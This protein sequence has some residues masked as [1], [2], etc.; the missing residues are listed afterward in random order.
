MKHDSVLARSFA[1]HQQK[2][3]RY[4]AFACCLLLPLYFCTVLRPSLNLLVCMENVLLLLLQPLAYFNLRFLPSSVQKLQMTRL[5]RYVWG[6]IVMSKLSFTRREF[7]AVCGCWF[8]DAASRANK[9]LSANQRQ[10]S[11]SEDTHSHWSHC[12]KWSTSRDKE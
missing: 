3:L 8:G 1:H 11:R 10:A 9:Q 6:A 2:R 7:A 12:R 5:T 4:G